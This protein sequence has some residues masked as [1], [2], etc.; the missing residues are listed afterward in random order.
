MK[1]QLFHV[2]AYRLIKI[3]FIKQIAFMSWIHET[4]TLQSGKCD[5]QSQVQYCFQS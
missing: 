5:S 1:F 2:K 4:P 3:F